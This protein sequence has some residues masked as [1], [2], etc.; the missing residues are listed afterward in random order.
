[1]LK[2][3]AIIN[4]QTRHSCSRCGTKTTFRH[5][6]QTSSKITKTLQ[7]TVTLFL[8]QS[9]VE[10][11]ICAFVT[12]LKLNNHP[13]ILV[14]LTNFLLVVF[15]TVNKQITFLLVSIC[16]KQQKLKSSIELSIM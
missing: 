11:M 5:L 12:I 10:V 9:L 4:N 14:T 16:S 7:S 2:V 3:L 13:A 15:I 6:L 1:M 8:D